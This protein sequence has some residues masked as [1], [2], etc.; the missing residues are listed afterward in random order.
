MNG[1][2]K[3][4]IMSA[5]SYFDCWQRVQAG[6]VIGY[7]TSNGDTVEL[8]EVHEAY[9]LDKQLYAALPVEG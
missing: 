3:V 1:Y 4:R 9:V 5:G 7:V 2:I 6:A 8:P